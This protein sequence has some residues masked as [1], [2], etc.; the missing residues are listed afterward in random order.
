MINRCRVALF[1]IIL[2][3]GGLT[4]AFAGDMGNSE[5]IVIGHRGAC[6]YVP[7]HTLVS[8]AMAYA[9]GAA[10]VEQDLVM[11]KDGVM[12][13]RHDI[14]L[15]STTN[16]AEV[17]PDRYRMVSGRKRWYASDFTLEEIKSLKARERLP[18]RF[19]Q[20]S[21]GFT[22][23]TFEEAIQLV[24][25]LNKRTGRNVGIYPETKSPTWHAQQ[26]LA[27][28]KPLLDMLKKYGYEGRDA[29]VYIQSFEQGNLKEIR[30]V[31]G[32]DLPI[33][34]LINRADWTTETFLDDIATY[35][36]G[37]GPSKRLIE[38][39]DCNLIDKN[40]LVERAHARGLVVHPYTF[41]ADNLAACYKTAEEEL[42]QFYFTYKVDGLFTDFADIAA[43]VIDPSYLQSGG[44]GVGPK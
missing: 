1:V 2:L 9:M 35:A 42:R 24:Q 34:Q 14:T 39:A 20:D 17:F 11:T 31:H 38:D 32:S 41:Q 29:K 27:M 15:E 22:V 4:H 36:D 23:P 37:I 16:I 28:E 26:G 25:E 8:Y 6:G 7:E 43:R 12:I 30:F 13:C 40:A 33:V 18:N 3:A 21:E 10:Y 5:K 19:R 44:M